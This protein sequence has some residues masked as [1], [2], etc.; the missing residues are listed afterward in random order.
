MNDSQT[1]NP[2]FAGWI[3]GFKGTYSGDPLDWME[4]NVRL[5]HSARSSEFDKDMAPW[6]NDI[7]RAVTNDRVKQIIVR[8]PTG[9]G[10]TTFLELICPYIVANQPGPMLLVEQTD[11]TSKDWAESR[12]MP[13]FE[14]CDPV[15]RLFPE[16]RHQKRKSA[17]LFPHMALFMS[18]A[19]M[20]GAQG[21]SMRYV[22][23]DE[24]WQF[25][26]GI[27]GE[28]QKR[29]HDR[30]NRKFIVCSQGWDSSHETEELWKVG[31]THEWGYEC[32]ACGVWQKWSWLGIKYNDPEE[33]K[34]WNWQALRDSVRHECPECG[35]VTA[36]STAGRR[37][38]SARSSYRAD[39]E[40]NA[41]EGNVNFTLP[42]WAV[43]WI[44][45]ADLAVEWVKANEA[46]RKGNTEPL[47]QFKQK[48][49]A[50]VWTVEEDRPVVNLM[51]ADYLRA[52]YADGQKVDGE[53]VRFLTVD[54]QQDHMWALI[55]A[56]RADGTS[57]LV[58]FGKVLTV[59]GIIDLQKRMGVKENM[60]YVD[61]GYKTAD[62]YEMC[63]RNS[64]YNEQGWVWSSGWTALKGSKQERFSHVPPNGK[65][66]QKFFSPFVKVLAGS[67][68]HCRL[69]NWSNLIAKDKLTHLRA[70]GSDIWAFPADVGDQ[71]MRQIVSEVKR[72]V[73]DNQT[74]AITQRYVAIDR[75]NHAWDC[76]CMQVVAAAMTRILKGVA[77]DESPV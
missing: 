74:K 43:W 64:K 34:E 35:H 16:D 20:S 1:L 11:D 26:P 75:E 61:S 29:L 18:G 30:V 22:Y 71:Y 45:W 70:A 7:I 19:N 69:V 2:A 65:S 60:V 15:A 73:V 37:A 14:A 57:M 42:A 68:K 6:L 25:K 49:G 66:V 40:G 59:D 52:D 28:L 67:G 8:M 53:V 62:V 31:R 63:S 21:K 39:T 10:K 47:K 12:L 41:I 27:L 51:A 23:C 9:A 36:N 33:G 32:A 55:R 54:V 58:W 56:W 44:D 48:R 77:N 50:Q 3:E 24:A 38:M 46:K 72:D 76:E 5:P 4:A 17:I 13:V